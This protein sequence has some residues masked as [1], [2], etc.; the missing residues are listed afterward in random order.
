MNS[1]RA[2][3]K[4][5]QEEDFPVIVISLKEN[6]ESRRAAVKLTLDGMDLPWQFHDAVDGRGGGYT[7]AS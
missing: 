4:G 5:G 1:P 6:N 7:S 2:G 3:N